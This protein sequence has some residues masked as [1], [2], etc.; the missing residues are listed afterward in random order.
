MA[1]VTRKVLC[2]G[3]RR[4]DGTA[5]GLS[6]TI[7]TEVAQEMSLSVRDCV[8]IRCDGKT[9]AITKAKKKIVKKVG[10]NNGKL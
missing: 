5:K 1:D 7:P 9:I 4:P 3:G 8:R 6:L 2:A 10:E